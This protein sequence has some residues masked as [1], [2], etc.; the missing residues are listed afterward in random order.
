MKVTEELLQ[1]Y[2]RLIVR[3]G[4][5]VQPGQKVQLVASVEQHAFAAM[6]TAQEAALSSV[7]GEDSPEALRFELELLHEQATTICG[8][9]NMAAEG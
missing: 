8:Y 9:L 2:A 4:A 5:N 6:L 3:T 7:Y 1:K